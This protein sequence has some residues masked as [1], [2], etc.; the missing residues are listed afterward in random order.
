MD[1]QLDLDPSSN[2]R[3]HMRLYKNVKNVEEISKKLFEGKLN[4]CVIKPHLI[5]D[6]FQVA[7]AAN[8][9]VVAENL[10]TKTIFTEILF[11][12]S[13]SKNITASLK[14]FGINDT[15]KD[16]LVVSISELDEVKDTVDFI[17][18]DEIS[19]KDINKLTDVNIVKKTYKITDEEFKN[20][21]LLD[22]IISRI[23]IK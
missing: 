2:S 1:W 21:D 15:D 20:N 17:N 18:G 12:L 23:A 7:V 19:V 13:I 4:C 6:P 8:K 16:L 9:A 5:V 14:T 22:S 3:V 10:T 11:N